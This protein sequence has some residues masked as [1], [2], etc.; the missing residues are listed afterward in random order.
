[1]ADGDVNF[2]PFANSLLSSLP[3]SH[4][5]QTCS[6]AFALSVART[7]SAIMNSN[8]ANLAPPEGQ[9][10]P[11]KNDPSQWRSPRQRFVFVRGVQ[12]SAMVGGDFV[13][14]QYALSNFF[15]TPLTW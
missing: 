14:M 8:S 9:Q 15:P 6:E 10:H 5:R 12:W 11:V 3:S 4:E 1:V 2:A 13:E 7:N